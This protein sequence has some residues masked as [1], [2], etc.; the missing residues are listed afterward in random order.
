MRILPSVIASWPV[1]SCLAT[2]VARA[3]WHDWTQALADSFLSRKANLAALKEFSMISAEE[4]ESQRATHEQRGVQELIL[5]AVPDSSALPHLRLC[6][7]QFYAIGA[8]LYGVR[9]DPEQICILPDL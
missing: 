8:E 7:R 3:Q 2:E 1:A 5:R 9:L 6:L 4:Y